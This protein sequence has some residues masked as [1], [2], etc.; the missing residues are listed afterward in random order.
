MS[1]NAVF[2]AI[3][4][5]ISQNLLKHNQS[6]SPPVLTEDKSAAAGLEFGLN[7]NLGLA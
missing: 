4:D 5:S 3:I 7:R 1:V 2:A 6:T